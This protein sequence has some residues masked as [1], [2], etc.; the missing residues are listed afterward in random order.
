MVG[1]ER[2]GKERKGK[3]RKNSTERGDRVGVATIFDLLRLK[4]WKKRQ[5]ALSSVSSMSVY[6]SSVY[7]R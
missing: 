2:K 7:F 4:F 3:E 6:V 5:P 1:L